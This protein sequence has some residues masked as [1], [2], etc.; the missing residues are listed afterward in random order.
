[1]NF[2]FHLNHSN[3]HCSISSLLFTV[4]TCLFCCFNHLIWNNPSP[5][6]YLSFWAMLQFHI[7]DLTTQIGSNLLY[8]RASSA[9]LIVLYPASYSGQYC[10]SVLDIH[11]YRC[12]KILVCVYMSYILTYSNHLVIWYFL[13]VYPYI[14]RWFM[15]FNH[16]FYI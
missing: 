13:Y 3:I 9:V 16:L 14:K 5:I 12:I 2:L 7:L 15:Y 8:H 11:E 10:L 1:M 6:I 4:L